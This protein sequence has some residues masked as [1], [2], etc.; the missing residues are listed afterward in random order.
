MI[1]RIM[2]AML[3]LACVS[4]VGA[5][6]EVTIETKEIHGDTAD[7]DLGQ[8]LIEGEMMSMEVKD[9]PD[10]PQMVFNGERQELTLI[11]HNRGRYAVVDEEM[12]KE[13]AQQVNAALQMME[14]NLS[15]MPA[16]QREMFEKMM[17]D[18]MPQRGEPR[19]KTE[20]KR[21]DEKETMAGYPCV[22]Y[23][24]I[25]EGEK[26]REYWVT[27]WSKVEGSE[28]VSK[29]YG[30][31]GE[32]F[33]GLFESAGDSLPFQEA[34]DANPFDEM[35]QLNGFPVVTRTFEG[36]SLDREATLKGVRSRPIDPE[37][38]APPEGYDK[39]QLGQN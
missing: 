25:R 39:E 17:K 32:F 35:S 8:M 26:V 16:E 23:E 11:D 29:M 24:A 20:I 3:C 28:E 2:A 30:K 31:L 33:R 4:M 27:D 12:F 37:T 34:F 1:K 18:K 36:G 13:I 7:I 10:Q 19:A 5:G 15:R 9:D 14:Q 6:V 22:K 38:F 21:T